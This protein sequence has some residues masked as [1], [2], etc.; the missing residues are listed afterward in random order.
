MNCKL[1][2]VMTPSDHW[3]SGPLT[4][5]RNHLEG[6][7]NIFMVMGRGIPSDSD[8][9]LELLLC[10]VTSSDLASEFGAVV[11]FDLAEQFPIVRMSKR[12]EIETMLEYFREDLI[13]L[14][15]HLRVKLTLAEAKKRK[16]RLYKKIIPE[17]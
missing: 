9:V 7:S 3:R 11:N 17:K 14:V 15:K 12:R 10:S 5:F 4:V 6:G 2:G 16:E 1:Y 13:K 8:P